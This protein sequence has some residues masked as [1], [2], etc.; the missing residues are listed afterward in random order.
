[1]SDKFDNANKKESLSRP[2]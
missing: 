2:Q 1:V